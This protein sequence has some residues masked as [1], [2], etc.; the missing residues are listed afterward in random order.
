MPHTKE[1]INDI[2]KSSEV[3]PMR[4]I[5]AIFRNQTRYEK[6]CRATVNKSGVGFCANHA[7]AGTDLALWMRQCNYDGIMRRKIGGTTMYGGKIISRTNLC[8]EISRH[9]IEQL[10]DIANKR[11][12]QKQS[13]SR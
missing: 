8:W 1:E 4:A 9:Y 2:L 11:E 12:A 13:S 5:C 10:V 3:A 6:S 7:R